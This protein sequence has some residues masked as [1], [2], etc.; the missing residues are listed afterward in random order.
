MTLTSPEPLDALSTI[1]ISYA[2]GSTSIFV[3]EVVSSILQENKRRPRAFLRLE[4][5]L[6]GIERE[7]IAET[8]NQ[9]VHI[10]SWTPTH[11]VVIIDMTL[12]LLA[13]I[14]VR[15]CFDHSFKRSRRE[16]CSR[17]AGGRVRG[18][19]RRCFSGDSAMLPI[20]VA[21]RPGWPSKLSR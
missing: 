9:R 19:G 13:E 15:Y 21:R 10:H 17:R 4:T 18:G 14:S 12:A 3:A 5:G 8:V 6:N 7:L 1:A 20:A 2:V 16:S 11:T